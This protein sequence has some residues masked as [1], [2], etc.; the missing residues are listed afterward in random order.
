MKKT[1]N[2]K[3]QKNY[4]LMSCVVLMIILIYTV[5]IIKLSV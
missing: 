5:T 2:N 1:P 4:A 3:K